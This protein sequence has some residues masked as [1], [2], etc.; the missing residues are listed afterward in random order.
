MIPCVFCNDGQGVSQQDVDTGKAFAKYEWKHYSDLLHSAEHCMYCSVVLQAI[1]VF[2][3]PEEE[4][5]LW[6]ISRTW[7]SPAVLKITWTYKVSL[8]ESQRCVR[9]YL[10]PSTSIHPPYN[11]EDMAKSSQ[12]LTTS[13]RAR[14]T[15]SILSRCANGLMIALELI[16]PVRSRPEATYRPA[17]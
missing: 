11:V 15:L 14:K 9:V 7:S 8:W 17:C 6:K 16:M 4:P 2:L 1:S 13:K 5:G 12:N 3:S 10:D